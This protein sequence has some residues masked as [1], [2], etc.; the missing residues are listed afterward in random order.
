[1]AG[2]FLNYPFDEELFMQAWAE[3]PD[4]VKTALLDSGV[5]VEDSQIAGQIA[6][7]GNLY[8]CLLYTSPSPRD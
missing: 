3:E 1:M 4:P 5:M 7:G 6:G 2:T 8:T